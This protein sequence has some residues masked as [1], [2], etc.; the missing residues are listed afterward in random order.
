[1]N[2]GDENQGDK[3][4]EASRKK[5]ED[6]RKKGQIVRSPDTLALASATLCFVA[7]SIYFA[8]SAMEFVATA[9]SFLGDHIVERTEVSSKVF[10][11]P[12]QELMLPIGIL[13]F[14][15]PFCTILLGLLKGGCQLTVFIR[16]ARKGQAQLTSA[17]V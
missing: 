16:P 11:K 9:T 17:R 3:P 14:V 7:L 13:F 8:S 4:H 12:F 1:M 2:P 5:L 6:A 15:V 10:R